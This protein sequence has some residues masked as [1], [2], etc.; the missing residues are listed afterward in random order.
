MST[1]TQSLIRALID[2]LDAVFRDA[3]ANGTID[4]VFPKE[5][6]TLNALM[7]ATRE[8]CANPE[9]QQEFMVPRFLWPF[10]ENW[11]REKGR[12]L[13]KEDFWQRQLAVL[14]DFD[15]KHPNQHR[16]AGMTPA[17]RP[18]APAPQPLQVMVASGPSKTAIPSPSPQSTPLPRSPESVPVAGRGPAPTQAPA[19]L[20]A[21]APASQV[22]VAG[23][24]QHD[25]PRQNKGKGKMVAPVE[26]SEEECVEDWSEED[27]EVPTAKVPPQATAVEKKRPTPKSSGRRRHPACRRCLRSG[28]TCFEQTGT[29]TACV[30]CATVKMRYD[31]ADDEEREVRV[32]VPA[33]ALAKKAAPPKKL[34]PPVMPGPSKKPAPSKKP[35]SA[36]P[37]PALAT[38]TK[39][40]KVVK[41][42]PMVISEDNDIDSRPTKKPKFADLDKE[43][44]IIDYVDFAVAGVWQ[45]VS[46]VAEDVSEVMERMEQANILVDTWLQKN[47]T[48]EGEVT[49]WRERLEV[50]E[51]EIWELQ[52]RLARAEELL[53]ALMNTQVPIP[54]MATPPSGLPD[55]QPVCMLV[56]T[57]AGPSRTT[58]RPVSPP[59]PSQAS[60]TPI[61][62]TP[63]PALE[64]MPAPQGILVHETPAPEGMPI[65]A[66]APA[67]Q[68]MLVHQNALAAQEMP[69]LQNAPAAEEMPVLDNAPAV[70]GMPSHDNMLAFEDMP[71]PDLPDLKAMPVPRAVPVPSNMPELPNTAD[72]TVSAAPAPEGPLA[73]PS[74]SAMA[75]PPPITSPRAPVDIP[76]IQLL[77]P[78]PNTSQEAATYALTTLLQVPV[79]T[80]TAE[81]PFPASP[82]SSRARSRSRSPA[83]D[84][85]DLQQSPHLARAPTKCIADDSLPEPAAKE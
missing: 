38:S 75:P 40:R 61:P 71:A 9:L 81:D 17:V 32:V 20:P 8:T 34:A 31:P 16:P 19:H 7:R 68:E 30:F 3:V 52:D 77:P 2:N 83:I 26:E 60:V 50:Q 51:I 36:K 24:S 33:P 22:P 72:M 85:S 56:P 6:N 49:A 84:Q 62:P 13:V 65:H 64:E 53:K 28:R 67:A 14:D 80:S 4:R 39:R 70:D 1:Y 45:E 57:I 5:C 54:T 21:P 23:S 79:V 82:S 43:D 46:V 11:H 63:G 15:R 48:A 18:Q 27:E 69:V 35:V 25:G 59:S 41:S 66:E 78:T 10:T 55:P 29:G 76:T 44:D 37:K 12:G 42:D 73:L 74:T 58:P 47:V